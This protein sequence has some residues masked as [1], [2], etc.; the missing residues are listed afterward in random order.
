MASVDDTALNHHSLTH[1]Q[2]SPHFWDSSSCTTLLQWCLSRCQCLAKGWH[3]GF[4]FELSLTL[5]SFLWFPL[6]TQLIQK[7]PWHT[8]H[9]KLDEHSGI[10]SSCDS[11]KM[12]ILATTK[13]PLV[14]CR[15]FTTVL[16]THH[17][18]CNTFS[19]F[20][21][22]MVTWNDLYSEFSSR[23]VAVASSTGNNICRRNCLI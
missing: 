6:L 15:T 5:C 10:P 21:L 23:T 9:Q 16:G 13:T 20:S 1:S 7:E 3:L 19:L 17:H 8:H 14:F 2:S 12:T 18:I 22:E 11:L 4:S